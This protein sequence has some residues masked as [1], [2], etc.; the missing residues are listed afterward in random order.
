M[1]YLPKPRN[2]YYFTLDELDT[3]SDHVTHWLADGPGTV[4]AYAKIRRQALRYLVDSRRAERAA[5]AAAEEAEA[6]AAPA[7]GPEGG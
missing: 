2:G 4:G 5:R 6:R 1:S 7:P 3:V